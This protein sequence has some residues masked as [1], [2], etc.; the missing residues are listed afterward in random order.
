MTSLVG[1]LKIPVSLNSRSCRNVLV[2]EMSIVGPCPESPGEADFYRDKVPN[3]ELRQS[4][5]PG[6]TGYAQALSWIGKR[7]SSRIEYDLHYVYATGRE[8]RTHDFGIASFP[9]PSAIGMSSG[10]SASS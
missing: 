7:F 1:S 4:V 10:F 2:G 6:L 9:V 5:R 3:Y 8:C